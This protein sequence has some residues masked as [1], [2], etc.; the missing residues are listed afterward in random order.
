MV[1]AS[2]PYEVQS[3]VGTHLM[4]NL[5]SRNI[6]S[7]WRL[8]KQF[9]FWE[10]LRM[11]CILVLAFSILVW[12]AS[13]EAQGPIKA[14][15]IITKITK[16][17][18]APT[19]TITVV[20][21]AGK[22]QTFLIAEQTVFEKVQGKT[23]NAASFL[24]EHQGQRV[25]ITGQT[26]TKPPTA[27]KVQILLPPAVLQTTKKLGK[28]HASG[29]VAMLQDN[30][31]M[32]RVQHGPAGNGIVG[33]VTDVSRDSK[34]NYGAMTIK[35][36]DGSVRK[37]VVNQFTHFEKVYIKG[38]QPA[39]FLGDFRT[40]T[41]AILPRQNDP[42]VAA[43]VEIV[44]EG[45]LELA[46]YRAANPPYNMHIYQLTPATKF[47]LVRDGKHT[48]ANQ[49]VLQ[50]G[51]HL[52]IELDQSNK[53]IATFVHVM[54]PSSIIG[55]VVGL[56]GNAVSVVVHIKAS[57]DV[58]THDDVFTVGLDKSTVIEGVSGKEHAVVPPIF[59][60]VGK[61]V[62][63]YPSVVPPHIAEKVSITFP[64]GNRTV[65]GVV[66]SVINA[67]LVISVHHNASATK[68]AY[69]ETEAFVLGPATAFEFV[70]G[71][72]HVPTNLAAVKI[73]TQVT[74]YVN[75]GPP[76]LATK[77]EIPV[78]ASKK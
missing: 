52:S 60:Q 2:W 62:T 8:M 45:G 74:V 24:A 61:K 71:S 29:Y 66:T 42:A 9:F 22:A 38:N 51:E 31:I 17:E 53:D 18:N 39:N 44:Q 32:L 5:I 49:A 27:N 34:A 57:L 75:A 73:G 30:Y 11:R 54:Q 26:G 56:T 3:V 55:Q 15:G 41:V 63:V 68:A 64:A 48:L 1:A 14:T 33:T 69:D 4:A 77:V 65:K 10:V 20:N 76:P 46:L 50:L 70:Q 7:R 12:P 40:E 6:G 25:Q 59:L 28:S 36:A 37:F 16:N 78:K 47:D 43:V 67:S 35:S 72:K 19:G 23:V 21:A 13:T 58:P